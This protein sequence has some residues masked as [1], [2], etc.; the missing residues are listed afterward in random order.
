MKHSSKNLQNIHSFLRSNCLTKIIYENYP[1]FLVC[2]NTHQTHRERERESVCVCVCVCCVCVVCVC[3]C[4]CVEKQQIMKSCKV[5]W[6]TPTH[7]LYSGQDGT[8]G[9]HLQASVLYSLLLFS[10]CYL[11]LL[12][13]HNTVHVM[14]FCNN[15]LAWCSLFCDWCKIIRYRFF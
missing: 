5:F 8:K 15:I 12:S 11:K 7:K 13:K 9:N 3:V 6:H 4:V 14:L 1:L 2:L 10:H